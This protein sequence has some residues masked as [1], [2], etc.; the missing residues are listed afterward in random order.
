VYQ[1]SHQASGPIFCAVLG[2][3]LALHHAARRSCDRNVNILSL[4]PNNIFN[5]SGF[6]AERLG[7]TITSHFRAAC[8]M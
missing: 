5:Q 7:R 8:T 4:D 1:I 2:T 3:Y 6:I